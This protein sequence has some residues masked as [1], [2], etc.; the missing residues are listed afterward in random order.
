MDTQVV[1]IEAR[2]AEIKRYAEEDAAQR[3]AATDH[4]AAPWSSEAVTAEWLTGALCSEVPGAE[5]I[6]IELSELDNGSNARQFIRVTYNDAGHAAGLPERMIAKSTP[7]WKQRLVVGLTGSAVQ[8]WGFYRDVRA[9]LGPIESPTG[10][11]GVIDPLTCRSIV[12]IEDIR[13]R[14]ATWG[15]PLQLYVDRADAESMVDVL[16]QIHGTMWSNAKLDAC[17]WLR[18]AKAFQEHL[19]ATVAFEEGTL[20][21][22]DRARERRLGPDE[23]F[24]RKDE[25]LPALARSLEMNDAQPH[26]LLHFDTHINNWYRTNAGNMGIMDWGCVCR[27][28]WAADYAYMIM[29]A[30]TVDDR[31]AWE[32]DLL[33]RYLER[34][35]EH[36]GAPLA[37]DEAWLRYRQQTFHGLT[38][39]L[40]TIGFGETHPEMQADEICATIVERM[41]HAVTDLRAF[42][43]LDE[44]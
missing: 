4:T 29:A 2:V 36:G 28:N 13:E 40:M 30:L 10:M 23:F 20:V 27:G 43:A 11:Y 1:D 9:D 12:L 32:H 41:C 6:A 8:E 35:R 18:T 39:W 31:H 17:D 3:P 33:S 26:T 44:A 25:I 7:D 5:V 19:N 14:V 22:T 21:G 16:A 15:N 24:A 37:F 34:L 38:F 42:E